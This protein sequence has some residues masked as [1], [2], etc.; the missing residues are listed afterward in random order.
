[1][2]IIDISSYNIGDEIEDL[3]G[4][5]DTVRHHGG[6]LFFDLRDHDSTIQVVTDNPDEFL[7]V[8]NEFYLSVTGI[9]NKREAENINNSSNFGEYEIDLKSLTII[10]ESKT[11]PFQIYFE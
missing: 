1:M 8:K 7:N 6:L 2:K 10:S 3:R 5:V 4:W 9:L 11:L